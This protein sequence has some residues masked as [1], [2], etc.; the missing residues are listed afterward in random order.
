MPDGLRYA[1]MAGDKSNHAA[2]TGEKLYMKNISSF[3]PHSDQV[4]G[5]GPSY[6]CN[7]FGATLPLFNNLKQLFWHNTKS[8]LCTAFS[9]SN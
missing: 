8:E 6:L 9:F 4:D 3:E 1:D 7:L 2:Q 5:I